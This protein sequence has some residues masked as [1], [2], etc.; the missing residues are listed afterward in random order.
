MSMKQ[1]I[2]GFVGAGLAVTS[3]SPANAGWFF[4]G[5]R[6]AS[7]AGVTLVPTSDWNQASSRPGKQGQAWTHDGFELNG[8]EFFAAIPSGQPIYKERDKQRNPMPKFDRTMLLPDLS[9]F[10]ERSFRAKNAVADFTVESAAPATFGGHPGIGV[11]YRYSLR[12]DELTRRGIARLA[13][14]DGKLYVAN[15]YAPALHFYA[16]GLPEAQSLMDGAKF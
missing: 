13:V 14:A 12:N 4:P 1:T 3:L 9:D 16:A 10:F 5:N 11:T 15:F 2:L 6:T 7:V 8:L